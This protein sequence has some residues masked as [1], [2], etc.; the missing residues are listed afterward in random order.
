MNEKILSLL[1]K[2]GP[3]ASAIPQFLKHLTYEEG[4]ALNTV[5][6]YLFDLNQWNL[7]L[8]KQGIKSLTAIE[9]KNLRLCLEE[10]ADLENSSIQRKI[11][12]FKKF[13]KYLKKNLIIKQD[14]TTHLPSPKIKKHLPDVLNEEEMMGFLSNIPQ[15]FWILFLVMYTC[16]L[17]ISEALNLRPSDIDFERNCIRV[18]GKGKKTREVPIIGFLARDLQGHILKPQKYVFEK[19]GKAISARTVQLLTKKTAVLAG[20]QKNVTPHTLRHS[21]ATHLL[22]NGSDLRSIQTLLGHSSLS[23]TQIYTN[24]DYKTLAKEYDK[25]HPL[26][27][28]S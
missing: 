11:A 7:Y 6:S 18:L 23:T 1:P 10:M 16:G 2:T 22:A 9:P 19:N 25:A 5:K 4:A 12:A 27:K 28:K 15:S 26:A 17:R 21:F 8:K 13:A 20:I 24:L 3:L 14:L